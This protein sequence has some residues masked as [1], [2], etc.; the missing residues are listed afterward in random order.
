[1]ADKKG[2]DGV[3]RKQGSSST[4]TVSG[5]VTVTLSEEDC[6]KLIDIKELLTCPP[7]TASGVLTNW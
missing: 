1:M 7:A 3:P 6:Q 5:P 2:F 4:T